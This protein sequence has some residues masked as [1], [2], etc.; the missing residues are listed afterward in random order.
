M[1]VI[2]LYERSESIRGHPSD[3]CDLLGENKKR[4]GYL[5]ADRAKKIKGTKL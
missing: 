3:C 1:S 2:S 5:Y 4:D